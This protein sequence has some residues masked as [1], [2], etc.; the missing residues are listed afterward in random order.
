MILID[1]RT[2]CQNRKYVMIGAMQLKAKKSASL[3]EVLE[4]LFPD[5]SKTTL[6]SWIKNG[7]FIRDGQLLRSPQIVISKGTELSFESKVKHSSF[8]IK[9]LYEDKDIVVVQ[10]PAG[11]LSVATHFEEK[12]TVHAALKS[13]GVAKRVLPVH[14][15]DRETSGVM[16]FA[17]TER[18]K[19]GLKKQFHL[20][21]MGRQ[22]LAVL[23]GSI[24]E[25]KG[26]WKSMLKEDANYF[27]S[28]HPEG[29]EAITHYKVVQRKGDYT[30]VQVTLETGRKNQIRA[31]ASE[32]GFP[33][34]GDMKYGATKNPLGRLGL[35]ASLLSFIH[36]VTK[37]K[38]EF[39][40]LP[41]PTFNRYFVRKNE[42]SISRSV[43]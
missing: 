36:P 43:G 20:H 42:A 3:L 38:M 11:L 40:S 9:I 21:T 2:S 22:Y 18:A 6:R 23:E 33:V 15:L 12:E 28:S 35:H 37:K 34:V 13:R 10:K 1:I 29:K 32:A 31:H 7:R 27:V 5:S 8:G 14:R 17:Y 24:E 25:K 39:K 19:E 16:V 26:M 4:E 30:A 41:P